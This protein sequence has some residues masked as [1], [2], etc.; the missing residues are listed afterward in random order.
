[1]V[2]RCKQ[3]SGSAAIESALSI[4]L[5]L[6]VATAVIEFSYWGVVRHLCRQAL[7][8]SLRI[9]V[10][11]HGT[12]HSLE[13]AFETTRHSRLT[14]AWSLKIIHPDDQILSDFQEPF[15]SAQ[16]G[17]PVIRNDS[18][19]EQHQRFLARWPDGRG[20][21][22]D[23][24]IFEANILKVE[25]TYHHRLLSPWFRHWFGSAS[26]RLTLEAAMQSDTYG[27]PKDK[28]QS[29]SQ[30]LLNSASYRGDGKPL[31]PNLFHQPAE[32]HR[33]SHFNFEDMKRLTGPNPDKRNSIPQL[34]DGQTVVHPG[35]SSSIL[36]LHP[37]LAEQCGTLMCCSNP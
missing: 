34:V 19:R 8:E 2:T 30:T 11:E 27:S 36:P 3:Q 16:Q 18:Q 6:L 21:A 13:Q 15:L 12:W 23:K 4:L 10:S 28:S 9:A 14:Q 35:V 25:L 37:D 5:L 20:P 26:T 22:S 24:T 29:T 33:R 1:M 31:S 7:H 32:N 17:R